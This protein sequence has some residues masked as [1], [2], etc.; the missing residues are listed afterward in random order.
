MPCCVRTNGSKK[1]YKQGVWWIAKQVPVRLNTLQGR[2]V[3]CWPQRQDHRIQAIHDL[4]KLRMCR[5]DSMKMSFK[6]QIICLTNVCFLSLCEAATI[7]GNTSKL[8][9]ASQLGTRFREALYLSTWTTWN[10]ETIKLSK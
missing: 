1:Q 10:T 9:C 7:T 5:E 2:F 8:F 6:G 3:Y 4:K